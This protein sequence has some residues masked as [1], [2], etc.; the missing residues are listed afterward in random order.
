[1]ADP[2]LR[3]QVANAMI[4]VLPPIPDGICISDIATDMVDVILSTAAELAPQS[5][6]PSGA[7][8]W[9][10]GPGVEAEINAAW[11]H[12]EEARRYLRAESH[13]SNLRK[14]VKMTGKNSVGFVRLP[15]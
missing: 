4:A 5:K 15:C 14:V 11:Q 7:Q 1:M 9:C 6:R 8:G 10:A 13:N 12:R 3:S 2:K